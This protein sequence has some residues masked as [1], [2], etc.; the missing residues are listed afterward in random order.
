[1]A[2]SKRIGELLPFGVV[3]LVLACICLIGSGIHA[4]LADAAPPTK[5]VPVSP[6]LPICSFGCLYPVVGKNLLRRVEQTASI[7]ARRVT[8]S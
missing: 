4:V 7:E 2:L 1:M 5:L 6:L 8:V 3:V